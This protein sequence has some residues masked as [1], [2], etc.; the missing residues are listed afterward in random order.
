MTVIKNIT[1]IDKIIQAAIVLICATFVFSC[2]K[3]R[4]IPKFVTVLWILII[5]TVAL[6]LISGFFWSEETLNSQNQL[7]IQTYYLYLIGYLI[8]HFI[9]A[10][11]YLKTSLNLPIILNL[12]SIGT[13]AKLKR[14][15]IIIWCINICFYTMVVVWLTV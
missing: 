12:F 13:E 9:F 4:G 2:H 10:M 3:C 14:S 5:I 6:S 1:L 7:A 8:V 15:N 11:E